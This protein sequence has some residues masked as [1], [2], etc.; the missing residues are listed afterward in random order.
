MNKLRTI[1]LSILLL[2][3]V[4]GGLP[5]TYTLARWARR[6]S[7]SNH[8][9]HR[10]HSR[11]WWR[12]HRAR[13]RA[14]RERAMLLRVNQNYGTT[15]AVL[16]PLINTSFA[17]TPANGAFVPVAAR[18]VQFPFGLVPPHAWS[19]ARVSPS[20]EVRFTVN[21]ADGHAAGTAIFAPVAVPVADNSSLV[22][23]RTK[24]IGGTPVAL[25]RRKVID[26]MVSEGGWVVNDTVREIQGRHVFVVFAQTGTPGTPTKSLTFY[27][28]E[29]DGR[30]YSL[31]TAAPLEFAEPVA[32]G[33]EQVMASLRSSA[34]N[35]LAEKK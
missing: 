22:S 34:S 9:R 1:L 16:S 10:H 30:I 13:Q 20:G 25:L 14:R 18:A 21:T 27:F 11:A 24:L 19:G 2:A 12:R 3:L 29:L 7:V 15:A 26:R 6:S 4:A 23:A 33:S 5:V 31:A 17:S 32:N 28:T 8:G 35:N